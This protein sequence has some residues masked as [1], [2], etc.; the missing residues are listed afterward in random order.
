MG[1]DREGP[2]PASAVLGRGWIIAR[3]A[4]GLTAAGTLACYLTV[5]IVWVVVALL[6]HGRPGATE[7]GTTGWLLL[8]SVTVVMAATGVALGLALALPWGMRL[9]AA[10]VLFFSWMGSGFLGSLVPYGVVAA[11]L[12]AAGVRL[13]DESVAESGGRSVAGEGGMSDWETAFISVGFVGMAVG[14]VVALP[15]YLRERWPHAFV[16]RVGDGAYVAAPR[17]HLLLVSAAA[18]ALAA[19]WL[20]WAFGGTLGRNEASGSWDLNGR[21]LIGSGAIWALIGA[22]GVWA[23]TGS[24]R[25][26]LPM[27][28]PVMTGFVASGSLFAWNSWR[29]V[30]A[31]LRPGDYEPLEHPA[32][33]VVEHGVAMCAGIWMFG[34]IIRAHRARVT[35]GDAGLKNG[36]PGDRGALPS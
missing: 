2:P 18:T 33:A 26:R 28:L 3:K 30:W 12:G 19:L 16:G 17:R 31:V 22:C 4:A 25:R 7:G 27:W 1:I 21:L 11:L 9:P 32:V 24:P 5:K 15:I 6:G 23:L 8:N 29:F 10:P 34:L 13:G 36:T 14:L 20:F 35:H